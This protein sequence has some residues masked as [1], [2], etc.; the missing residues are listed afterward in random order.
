MFNNFKEDTRKVL[1]NAKLEM[2][3]LKHPYIGSEHLLLSILKNKNE[4]SERLKDF[5]LTYDIFKSEIIKLVGVG[6]NKS[7]CLLY[8]PLLKRVMESA[9]IDSRENNN[10]NVTINHLFAAL[11]EEGEG[12][13]IRVM[14]GLDIDLDALYDEFSSKIIKFRK[15]EKLEV[16]EIG[17]DL[18][19]K[20]LNKEIDRVVGR[21][22]EIRKILE[23]LSRKKK[24][25]PI[26][27]GDA[28][29]GKTAIVEELAYLIVTGDVPIN[30]KNK[31]IISIDM[32]S[33]V[34]GT[35]YR[36]EFE[37]RINK[38]L[39]ELEDNDDII[40]FIDEIHTIVGAGGAEGAI[41][42]SNIFKP[43]L[44]RNKMRLI[45]ATTT[46]EYK[47]FIENDKAL[48]RRFQKVNIK[49]PNDKELKKIL[50]NIKKS[51]EDYH[52]VIIDNKLL[53]EIITLSNKYIQNRKQP[54]KAI[55]ILDEVCAYV[56]LKE[57]KEIKKYN[58]LNKELKDI[59][60]TKKKEIL[61]NNFKKATD[62]KLKENKLMD[63][64]NKLELEICKEKNNNVV[65]LK[66]IVKIV[67]EKANIPIYKRD[68]K[69]KKDILDLKN[70]LSK[71]II[72]QD[73]AI[74]ELIKIYK[75]IK[76]NFKD[77]NPYSILF[78][79]P[80]GVGKTKM[81]KMF[82]KNI[83]RS[84]IKLDMSEYSESHS[85]S[86]LI[87][88]PAGYVGYSDSKNIFD[89]IKDNPFSVIILDELEKAHNNI[90]SLFLS[91]LDEGVVHDAKGELINFKNTIIIMT[92][93][94]GYLKDS[95]GFNKLGRDNLKENFS[96]PFINR[97]D[98]IVHFNGMNKK[99]IKTIINNNISKLKEKY[100]DIKITVSKDVIEEIIELS[101]YEVSG[102]R[103]IEK[104]IKKYLE[105][106][107]VSNIIENVDE[108]DIKSLK[109]EQLN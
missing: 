37:E 1:M 24:N 67:S 58:E 96:I 18:T 44:A 69:D 81:A 33:A 48:D 21:E 16:D 87:G 41:D 104:I 54:D 7:T 95:I 101:N 9:M 14:L 98:N 100:C 84:V 88:S 29:V 4:V 3:E 52:H 28:G 71:S 19:K 102:A 56:S 93:N 8:T 17:V 80:S 36:G 51:Y 42:A 27:I 86:K 103:K 62:L 97:I 105:D 65:E 50:L 61:H 40:L 2:Q 49:E 53:G 99:M 32:A 12:V 106:R 60:D 25:N 82:A 76:L 31:R 91:I 59:I 15:N 10:G 35:K 23:I 11:L 78:V 77:D 57:N 43:A 79:G 74:L 75:Q 70:K 55:D 6:K 92:S 64:I 26:L 66:D 38:M 5:G 108:I 45:G 90:I 85:I 20:A 94:V 34:A 47:K 72:G 22:N 107:I 13:A 30:L 63:K 46:E 83:S 109:K 68:N 73:D 39:K 89:K